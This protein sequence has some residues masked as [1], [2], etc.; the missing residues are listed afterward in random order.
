MAPLLPA[1]P[2][3]ARLPTLPV[4]GLA[5]V[6]FGAELVAAALPA[7]GDLLDGVAHRLEPVQLARAGATGRGRAG[8]GALA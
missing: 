5:A 7:F 6:Q 4:A 1:V 8:L 3:P 2:G